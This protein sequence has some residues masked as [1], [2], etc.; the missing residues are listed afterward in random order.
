MCYVTISFFGLAG[1]LGRV[2]EWLDTLHWTAA[3]GFFWVVGV[4]R[5][6]II[7]GLGWLAA[8]GGSRFDRIRKLMD[9][10]A[11]LRARNFVNRWGV[12]A[13]PACFLTIGFQTAVIITTGFTRMPL[14]RW[15]PAMLVGT[16]IWGTIYGTV[17][18]AVVWAWLENPR[19][20]LILLALAALLI[21]TVKVVERRR[22]TPRVQKVEE[23]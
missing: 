16:L 20:A 12:L 9:H 18:M 21:V 11:Y 6:S 3:I 7:F 22:S 8:S 15:I 4:V 13:V 14:L 17:G 23:L 19:I 5:T 1:R 10:P 2:R